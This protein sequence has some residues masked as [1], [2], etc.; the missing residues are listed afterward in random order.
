MRL[1]VVAVERQESS[2]RLK[3]AVLGLSLVAGLLAMGLF[4][5]IAG[6]NPVYGLY[7]VFRSGFFS[8]YGLGESLAR[9]VPLVISGAGLCLAFRG[10]FW[11]IG[12]E[13]QIV[14]GAIA[15]TWCGLNA[16]FLPAPL[17]LALMA[18]SGFAAGALWC[19]AAAALKIKTRVNETIST[20]ML[21]YAI[22]EFVRYLIT[23]PW[24]GKTQHGFNYTDNLPAKAALASLPGTDAPILGIVIA[25]LAMLVVYLLGSRSRFGYELRVLGENP[26][27]ARYAGIDAGKTLFWASLVSGGL[28][29]LAGFNELAAH[30]HHM[31][32]PETI[33]ANYG[34]TAIIV[35]YLARLDARLLPLSAFFFAG[36]M[37]GGSAIQISLGL[38]A[39]TV[40]V[41]NGV[42][43]IFLIL[44]EFFEKNRVILERRA[45]S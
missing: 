38:P 1:R 3:L 14:A 30:H 25:A 5:A 22:A 33:S 41:F 39:A 15:A 34:F 7:R 37:V 20:L 12:A 26:D 11:N 28:A 19:L 9:A 35:A 2:R 6:A 4:F 36:I 32:Q 13:G 24:K 43:L 23:G 42:I 44:S 18:L 10:K 17:L 29:G 40:Q 45:S 27:A 16:G 31:T 21:N 8:V